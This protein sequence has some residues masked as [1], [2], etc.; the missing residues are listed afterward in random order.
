MKDYDLWKDSCL[1]QG[2]RSLRKNFLGVMIMSLCLVLLGVTL[3]RFGEINFV[4][5]TWELLTVE[6]AQADW[7]YW[8]VWVVLILAPL[9]LGLAFVYCT[10]INQEES[11][12]ESGVFG[13]F[14]EIYFKWLA[15]IWMIFVVHSFWW[16]LYQD[17]TPPQ[18]S[19]SV[20]P[21]V[22]PESLEGP[23]VVWVGEAASIAG[24]VCLFFMG[25]FWMFSMPVFVYR[26]T[27]IIA[28]LRASKEMVWNRPLHFLLFLFV[29]FL[30]SLAIWG[31]GFGLTRLVE[32]ASFDTSQGIGD[33]DWAPALLIPLAW[34]WCT[35][36]AV[37]NSMSRRV[38][39][40]SDSSEA[41]SSSGRSP[42]REWMGGIPSYVK[43]LLLIGVIFLFA[44]SQR[45]ERTRELMSAERAI[46]GKYEWQ[47]LGDYSMKTTY[48]V[49]NN[50]TAVKYDEWPMKDDQAWRG[51]RNTYFWTMIG[52][53]LH[54]EDVMGE[55][56]VFEIESNGNLT[57]K[58][59]Y[60]FEG[61]QTF[62]RI[63]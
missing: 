57:G 62:K 12:I 51:R 39:A 5:K 4:S 42:S 30:V 28:G 14:P 44:W 10:Q 58:K 20:T 60:N 13:C 2:F 47:M 11:L 18:N 41:P 52:D 24:P 29:L 54:V 40:P 43:T 34:V 53:E 19:Y 23:K 38:I 36:G 21:F 63:N 31:V 33:L 16:F 48:V 56:A 55:D 49:L 61:I 32:P 6:T 46:V 26:D 37:Y 9:A 8:I 17:M 25:F 7:H 45:E 59:D 50:G 3:A 35:L 27:G 15:V 1:N 22:I